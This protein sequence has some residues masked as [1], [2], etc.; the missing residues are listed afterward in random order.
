[1]IT[2]S[3]PN[4]SDALAAADLPDKVRGRHRIVIK[5]FLGHLKRERSPA[6]KKS[7]RQF[8]DH[9]V[10]TRR[11]KDWQAEQWRE[12]LNWFFREAPSRRRVAEKS[13]KRA[14]ATRVRD[15]GGGSPASEKPEEAVSA[16]S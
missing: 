3:F 12:G 7:A 5:W 16:E 2:V 4:W 11:P 8:I 10:E 1:M 13:P 9:L 14:V 6:S 15:A